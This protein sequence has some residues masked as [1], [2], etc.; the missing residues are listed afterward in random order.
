VFKSRN[1]YPLILPVGNHLL[2]FSTG[3][4]DRGVIRSRSCQ[5]DGITFA[6]LMGKFMLCMN[7]DGT[8]PHRDQPDDE[9]VGLSSEP[10]FPDRE[11]HVIV[12]DNGAWL[13]PP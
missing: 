11:L 2:R 4:F 13:Y 6:T 12:N 9:S 7:S 5:A 3:P 1:L 10:P 8:R